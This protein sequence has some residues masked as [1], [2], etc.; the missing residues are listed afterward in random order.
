MGELNPGQSFITREEA[1]DAFSLGE[2]QYIQYMKI[3]S[4]A[5]E[6]WPSFPDEQI[7]S[8]TLTTMLAMTQ[9]RCLITHLYRALREA[10]PHDMLPV[11]T[12]WEMLMESPM[13][14]KD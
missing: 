10:L 11:Q 3:Y 4:S 13:S 6:I 2:G 1:M 8:V 9:G 7:K 14:P 12:K 5:R